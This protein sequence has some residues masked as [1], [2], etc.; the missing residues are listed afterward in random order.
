MPF[1]RF[2][3]FRAA[4]RSKVTIRTNDRLF[5]SKNILNTFNAD[6]AEY[7]YINIDKQN[8]QIAI[9]FVDG[10]LYNDAARKISPETSGCTINIGAVLRAFGIRRLLKKYVT[11]YEAIN[12]MLVFSIVRLKNPLPKI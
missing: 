3:D 1:T 10:K 5:I 12:N 9:E 8:M 2:K 11:E 4:A 7:V 6:K